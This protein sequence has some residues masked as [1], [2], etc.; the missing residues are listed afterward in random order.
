MVENN[1]KKY[2][3][4]KAC[5]MFLRTRYLV[6]WC[7]Q[8]PVYFFLSSLTILSFSHEQGEGFTVTQL[9]S[10]LLTSE[11]P[12]VCLCHSPLR[13]AQRETCLLSRKHL[14]PASS[15]LL[16]HPSPTSSIWT[17][18]V[19]RWRIPLLPTYQGV[20]PR[21][22]RASHHGPY[23]EESPCLHSSGECPAR[24]SCSI[25]ACLGELPCTDP[26][27]D[28]AVSHWSASPPSATLERC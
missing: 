20:L 3:A 10:G 26:M 27:S 7:V 24:S 1:F 6:I 22:T 25:N 14:P 4:L 2:V 9:L 5:R 21:D 19:S 15:S 28:P 13:P 17:G 8:I 11:P 12:L 23:T 16:W 18:A